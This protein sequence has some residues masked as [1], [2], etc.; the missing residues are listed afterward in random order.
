[1]RSVE[2]ISAMGEGK[3]KENDGGVNYTMIY[4]RTCIC[5]NVPPAQK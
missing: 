1:M 5:H 3:R 2:T 4:W